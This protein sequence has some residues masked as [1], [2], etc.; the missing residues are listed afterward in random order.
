FIGEA[1]GKD[2]KP[3]NIDKLRQLEMNIQEDLARDEV[4]E[5]ARGALFGNGFRL[6]PL[7]ERPSEFFTE[8]CLKAAARAGT[9]LVRTPDLF[10]A[11]KYV[12]ESDD[13]EFARACRRAIFEQ[14]GGVVT[15]P[16]A[17]RANE[18]TEDRSAPAV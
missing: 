6:Q 12:R 2:S 1:E 18:M 15:F 10:F 3:I 5:P 14:A 8:K 11:A 17:P 13:T 9:A 4:T 16:P 7:S